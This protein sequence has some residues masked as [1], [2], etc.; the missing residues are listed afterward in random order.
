MKTS[1]LI[2]AL[3]GL[4]AM[5]SVASADSVDMRFL[6]TSAGRD[7]KITFGSTTVNVFAGQLRHQITNGT[8]LA[9]QLNSPS[10]VTFCTDLDQYVNSSYNTYQLV[11]LSGVPNPAMGLDKANAVNALY[12]AANSAQFGSNSDYAAAF[13]L[14]IWE[15]VN[16][17]DASIAGNGLSLTA[18][19][20][21]AKQTSGAALTAAVVNAYNSLVGQISGLLNGPRIVMGLKSDTH[22]DQLV[23]IPLP[24]GAAMAGLGL[25]MIALRR[26]RGN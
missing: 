5:A 15:V 10:M 18:G 12:L 9:A 19:N 24:T 25:G 7:V 2:V 17:Y 14:A 11:N 23:I 13:Q 20:F 1:S 26:R 3:A 21:K 8:G 22:Q 4:T 6:G 16:D